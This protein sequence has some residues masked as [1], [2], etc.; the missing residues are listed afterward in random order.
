MAADS[1]GC[2]ILVPTYNERNN[3]GPLLTGIFEQGLDFD[4]LFIDDN[5][6]D[7]TG[8]VLDELAKQYEPHVH[9]LHR[10]GK[11][12]IGSAHRDGIRWA[13]AHHYPAL[14]TMDSDFAHPPAYLP[15]LLA[16]GQGHDVVIGSR[17]LERDSLTAWS[18]FRTVLARAGHF[19]TVTMLRMPF[20]A[21]VAFRYYR[22]DTM[23]P[24]VFDLVRSSSYSFFFESL[25]VLNL[26]GF[27]IDQIPIH[28]LSRTS[29]TSKMASRDVATS[30]GFLL[31]LCA[32]KYLRPWRLRL[33]T[34]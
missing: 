1:D 20:D 30:I 14:I 29:G 3:V 18:L 22:L 34:A 15:A 16:A 21:T 12:G 26:N 9:V 25:F 31:L 10:P 2:L 4:V 27:A 33:R 17:Y 28:P 19:L 32:E 6:P 23:P 11:L 13:Y 5:S 8:E 7:G 24:G